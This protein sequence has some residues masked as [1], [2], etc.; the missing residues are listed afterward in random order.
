MGHARALLSAEDPAEVA[1]YVV[2]RNLSVRDTEKLVAKLEGR[3][4]K[5]RIAPDK[6]RRKGIAAKDADTLALEKEVSD[7]LGMGVS[8]DMKTDHQ[9]TMRIDFSS[10]DQLD[11]ILQR[12]AQTPRH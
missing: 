8:I 3:D 9:G 7:Q 11:D 5:K 10:L 6:A 1:L 4:V 12:L 2:E